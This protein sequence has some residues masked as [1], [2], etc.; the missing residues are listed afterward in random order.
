MIERPFRTTC[1]RG[2]LIAVLLG[3]LGSR[4]A[5]ATGL[6][7]DP[8][9]NPAGEAQESLGVASPNPIQGNF[10]CGYQRGSSTAGIIEIHASESRVEWEFSPGSDHHQGEIVH[11]RNG[12]LVAV[13]IEPGMGAQ[14]LIL[15]LHDL[16]YA[17]GELSTGQTGTTKG[18]CVKS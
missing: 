4:Q 3:I 13:P 5:G 7:S 2:A 17:F 16:T 15:N 9:G 14:T 1:L 12:E 8:I 18:Y 10:I 11:D 6:Y